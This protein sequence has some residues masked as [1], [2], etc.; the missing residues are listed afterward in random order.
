MGTIWMTAFW[1]AI[2]LY[3]AWCLHIIGKKT[4]TAHEWLSWVPFVNLYYMCR[5][6]GRPGWW[7][8]LLFVPLVNFYVLVVIWGDIA[9]RRNRPSWAGYFML[10]PVLNYMVLSRLAFLD[11]S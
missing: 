10:V 1:L 8:A 7:S 9:E 11:E 2:Y 6:A 4:G 5:I 3:F